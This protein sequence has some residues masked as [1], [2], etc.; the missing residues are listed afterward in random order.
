MGIDAVVNNI[1]KFSLRM[2][3]NV[4]LCSLKT[5]HKVNIEKVLEKIIK[6]DNLKEE[7]ILTLKSLVN[8]LCKFRVKEKAFILHIVEVIIGRNK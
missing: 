1:E 3:L 5:K 6:M 8:I 4:L 2:I 7:N